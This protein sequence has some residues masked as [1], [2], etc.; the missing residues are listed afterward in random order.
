[1]SKAEVKTP[2]LITIDTE[3]DNLWQISDKIQ[4]KNAH[5]IPRFQCLCEKY[6]LKPTYLVDYEMALSRDFQHFGLDVIGRDA[7]EIGMHLHAWNS[8]PVFDLTGNDSQ[9]KPYLIEYPSGIMFKKIQVLTQLLQDIFD[10]KIISHRAGRW[11][12]NN[13]YMGLLKQ[14]N[15]KTDC[16]VTPHVTWENMKGDPKGLGG[17]DYRSFPD[18]PYFPDNSNIAEPR[19]GTFLELPMTIIPQRNWFLLE[20]MRKKCEKN[21][22]I[23]TVL[24]Y[25][26]PEV[27]WLRPNGRNLPDMVK[28]LERAH[29]EKWNYVM[30]M[31]HSS[32]LMPRGSPTFKTSSSIEKLYRD[33][34]ILF[35]STKDKFAG[36]TIAEY[37]NLFKKCELRW[38]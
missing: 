5:Y 28:I 24:N 26:F 25:F 1:M 20:M 22:R 30:F 31:L 14:F 15:Y 3:G 32:E 13:Q 38:N 12:F 9:N 16:S 19:E 2:F 33:L 18:F 11:A 17:C 27:V 21:A 8:P 36:M 29:D 23:K 6:G 37:Y 10:I 4:T 34:E 7:A 35:H